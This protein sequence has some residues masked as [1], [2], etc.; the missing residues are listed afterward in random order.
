MCDALRLSRSELG[1]LAGGLFGLGAYG[2]VTRNWGVPNKGC[3]ALSLRLPRTPSVPP[4]LSPPKNLLWA[5]AATYAVEF[6]GT[7]TQL[8]RTFCT[9]VGLVQRPYSTN[10][11]RGLRC[12]RSALRYS[13]L[14]GGCKLASFLPFPSHGHS[15]SHSTLPTQLYSILLY[16]SA[17][18]RPPGFS[19]TTQLPLLPAATHSA[20]L[21]LCR[22]PTPTLRETH[23]HIRH[24]GVLPPQPG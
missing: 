17:P 9:F 13:V 21:P 12:I 18:T 11:T 14:A 6:G 22:P 3:S 24:Y 5:A 19:N 8:R 10:H 2:E 1:E 16:Y 20:A 4:P 23:T 7:T 15:H